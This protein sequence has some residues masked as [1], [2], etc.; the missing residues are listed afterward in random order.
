MSV[1]L[2]GSYLLRKYPEM[3]VVQVFDTRKFAG[4]FS[5][6]IVTRKI[7]IAQVNNVT[8]YL[9]KLQKLTDPE[10]PACQLKNINLELEEESATPNP[11]SLLFAAAVGNENPGVDRDS[12]G[13]SDEDIEERIISDEE[14]KLRVKNALYADIVRI[15]SRLSTDQKFEHGKLLCGLMSLSRKVTR[16]IMPNY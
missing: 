16:K 9:E 10:G 7:V 3:A 5:E 6:L 12:S 11:G 8:D 14:T 1:K 15:F 2:F 13:G 4:K